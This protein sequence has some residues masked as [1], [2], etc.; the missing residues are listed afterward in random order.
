[1]AVQAQRPGDPIE[2]LAVHPP[3]SDMLEDGRLAELVLE[4]DLAC[5][6]GGHSSI[7]SNAL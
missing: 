3:L 2:F 5:L 7:G 1:M 4:L 6:A